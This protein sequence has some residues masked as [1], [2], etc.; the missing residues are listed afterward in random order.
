MFEIVSNK[1]A[2]W[3]NHN[4]IPF[5]SFKILEYG[6]ETSS[7][8]FQK[9]EGVWT[10]LLVYGKVVTK[11]DRNNATLQFFQTLLVYS[12]LYIKVIVVLHI[13]ATLEDDAL[14]VYIAKIDRRMVAFVNGLVDGDVDLF[15]C[16]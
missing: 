13:I 16:T 5:Y 1:G 14:A 9:K 7:A 11:E 10:I 12:S 2:L 3:D 4:N 6:L 15:V 8:I